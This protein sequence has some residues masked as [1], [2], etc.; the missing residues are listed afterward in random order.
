[1]KDDSFP[2]D[3]FFIWFGTAVALSGAK[4]VRFCRTEDLSNRRQQMAYEF[5]FKADIH[6]DQTKLQIQF[7]RFLKPPSSNAPLWILIF[8]AVYCYSHVDKLK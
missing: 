7:S 8:T 6:P 3:R 4:F 2:G 1:M 5:F